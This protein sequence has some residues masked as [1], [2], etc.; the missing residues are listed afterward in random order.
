MIQDRKAWCCTIYFF[1]SI[2]L[3]SPYLALYFAHWEY[4]TLQYSALLLWLSNYLQD[5]EDHCSSHGPNH[6]LILKEWISNKEHTLI[7]YLELSTAGDTHWK[8]FWSPEQQ[9]HCRKSCRQRSVFIHDGGIRFN[10]AV[11]WWIICGE[12]QMHHC[13]FTL[14][15]GMRY[16]EVLRPSPS[17]SSA[18]INAT[19]NVSFWL[20]KFTPAL[21]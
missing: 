14:T 20:S 3:L 11:D 10:R 1:I 9:T 8:W 4:R 21:L 13:L 7:C 19:S 5:H 2:Q 16:P 15:H 6:L 12:A 18:L 17:Q